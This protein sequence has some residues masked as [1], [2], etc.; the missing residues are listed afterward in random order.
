M[1]STPRFR[2]VAVA[3]AVVAVPVAGGRGS[4]SG[5]GGGTMGLWEGCG[6]CFQKTTGKKS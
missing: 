6:L 5:S 2:V 1:H 3:V 4:G